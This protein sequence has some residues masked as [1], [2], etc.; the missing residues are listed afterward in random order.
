MI[1][2][3]PQFGESWLDEGNVYDVTA[4]IDSLGHATAYVVFSRSMA[5]Y[6]TYFGAPQGYAQLAGSVQNILGWSVVYRNAD[7]TIY[8]VAAG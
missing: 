3:D 2:S 5:A 8:R 6:A 1:P 7:T 4:W